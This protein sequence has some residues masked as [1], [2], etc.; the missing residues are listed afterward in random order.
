MRFAV[1]AEG[2][3]GEYALLVLRGRTP[4]VR[5][6]RGA[7]AKIHDWLAAYDQDPD[8][9]VA[10]YVARLDVPFLNVHP[11]HTEVAR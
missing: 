5:L 7:T 9:E 1:D 2:A 3:V 4:V 11:V 6:P 10:R 8:P